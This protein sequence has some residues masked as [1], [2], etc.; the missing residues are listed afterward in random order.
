ML[1]LE[2]LTGSTDHIGDSRASLEKEDTIID[3]YP[4]TVLTVIAV[5]LVGL[6]AEQAIPGATAQPASTCSQEANSCAVF[7]MT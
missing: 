3:L 2:V 1:V 5:T 6:V 4:K 7:M